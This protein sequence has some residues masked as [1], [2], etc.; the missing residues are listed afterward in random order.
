MS[1]ELFALLAGDNKD[2]AP[3]ISSDFSPAGNLTGG[4]KQVKAKLGLKKVRKWKWIP[5]QN[6]GRTDGF[7]LNHWRRVGEEGREYQFARFATVSLNFWG[8]LSMLSSAI[9]FTESSNSRL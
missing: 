1:R 9:F 6:P 3:L 5:F 4:Y 2:S 8:S 7:M